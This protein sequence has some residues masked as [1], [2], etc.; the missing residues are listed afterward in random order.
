MLP[1]RSSK[2]LQ[3]I[4]EEYVT[5]A[6]PVPS[7][8]I[9]ENYNLGVSPATVRNEM[10]YLEQEGYIFRPHHS[11]GS[12]PSDKGYRY[13]VES[14][15]RVAL[16]LPERRL[17]SHLFHQVEAAQEE[18]LN[19]AVT[20]A[21]RL[22]HNVAVA[23]LPRP[24]DSRFK[25]LEL[26]ALEDVLALLVLIL[27]GARV[28]QQLINFDQPLPQAEMTAMANRL[29]EAYRGL[30]ATQ[31]LAKEVML[32]VTETQLTEA[33]VRV[34][35]AEDEQA[36][37]KPYLE[38]LY[39]MLNQPEFAHSQRMLALVELVEQRNLLK[40]VVPPMVSGP[41]VQVIIGRENQS[42]AIHD[43]SVVISR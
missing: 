41:G 40:V 34:M 16:P 9:T 2:I 6:V 43:F 33:I 36:Y 24:A 42:E 4:V 17:I 8:D 20:L 19:L 35:Q 15:K 13:Y 21:S 12:V 22:A 25:H 3:S 37:D 31:I 38:G 30:N 11:A 28:K 5:K 10:A 7:H 23:A 29:N 27:H 39:F 14:I 26:V 1:P 18:W 32:S